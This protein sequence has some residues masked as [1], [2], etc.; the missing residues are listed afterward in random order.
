MAYTKG[1]GRFSCSL[2]GYAPCK[3][4]DE[5]VASFAYYPESDVENTPDSVFCSHGAGYN[6]KWNEVF[7]NMHLPSVLKEEEPE[8]EPQ[9][10]ARRYAE[11]LASDSELMAIFERTYGPVK[12]DRYYAMQSTPKKSEISKPYKAQPK[13]S[14]PEYLLVDGYNIIFAWDD[15][16]KLSEESLD[17][18]R[19]QLINRLRNYQ[20]Y[21]QTPVII[22]FDAYKVKDG[23][24]SIQHYGGL[25][26]VYTKE[27]ETAD[28]YIEK[29]TH[30]LAKQYK[31]RVATSDT[32][33]QVI[34]LGSGA[35]RIS[36]LAFQDEVKNVEKTIRE[37][38]GK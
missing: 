27:A 11:R 29:T 31:V 12:T 13:K 9:I 38:L 2:A 19:S 25:S 28:M 7:E 21:V 23:L 15:L 10:L 4:Q 1:L 32:L 36:A 37:F 24:G 35:R 18:A 3:N 22:V 6:V 17:L 33:E 34:I 8:E 16:K 26:V 5:I 20:G 14:G 30:N